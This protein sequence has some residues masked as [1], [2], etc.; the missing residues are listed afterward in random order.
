MKKSCEWNLGFRVLEWWE[1]NLGTGRV[2]LRKR[3]SENEIWA[4]AGVWDW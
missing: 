4:K 3:E 1:W 2:N